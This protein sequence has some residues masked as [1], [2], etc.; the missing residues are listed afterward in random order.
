M[1]E[2]TYR[3]PPP[4]LTLGGIERPPPATPEMIRGLLIRTK[5]DAVYV[6]KTLNVPKS[7][8][9]H[10]LLKLRTERKL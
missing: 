7:A 6:S 1:A 4:A 2:G 8:V 5:G 3:P 9:R 10:H